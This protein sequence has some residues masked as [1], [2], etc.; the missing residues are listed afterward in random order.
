MSNRIVPVQVFERWLIKEHRKQQ[1]RSVSTNTPSRYRAYA[2]GNALAVWQRS[3][4]GLISTDTD[5]I[6][7]AYRDFYRFVQDSSRANA[8]SGTTQGYEIVLGMLR[9]TGVRF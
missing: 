7:Q 4:A 2:V 1:S 9:R 8:S 6:T 5:L 3:T